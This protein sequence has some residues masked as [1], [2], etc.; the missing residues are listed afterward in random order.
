[1]QYSLCNQISELFP[2]YQ[3]LGNNNEGVEYSIGSIRI[4]VLLEHKDNQSLLAIEPTSGAA[5]FRILGQM[6]MHIGLLNQ[7]FPEKEVKGLIISGSIDESLKIACST[8]NLVSLK[9]YK[10]SLELEEA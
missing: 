10:M 9:T 8:T 2:E 5:D 4:D 1:M 6:L 7:R 3:I